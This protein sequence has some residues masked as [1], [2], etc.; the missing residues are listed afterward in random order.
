MKKDIKKNIVFSLVLFS[1]CILIYLLYSFIIK[2]SFLLPKN[3]LEEIEYKEEYKDKNIDIKYGN[4]ILGYKKVSNI[5]IIKQDKINTNK[6]KTYK[7]EYEAKYK[8]KKI[9]FIKKIKVVDKTSPIIEV[10]VKEP[11]NICPRSEY[12]NLNVKATDKLN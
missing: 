7:I 3:I 2:Q 1:I 10:D 5:K 6:L 8:S 4:K 9:K 12:V 11:L